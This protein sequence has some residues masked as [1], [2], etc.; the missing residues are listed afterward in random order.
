MAIEQGKFDENWT[1]KNI[2]PIPASIEFGEKNEL[3]FF[4]LLTLLC[5]N[6]QTN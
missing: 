3:K 4:K 1:K 2:E 6:E 5:K